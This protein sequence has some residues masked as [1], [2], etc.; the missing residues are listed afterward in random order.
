[1]ERL[2]DYLSFKN[3]TLFSILLILTGCG[4][5]VEINSPN[6]NAVHSP[7]STIEFDVSFVDI[8]ANDAEVMVNYREKGTSTYELLTELAANARVNVGVGVSGRKIRIDMDDDPTASVQSVESTDAALQI[9]E[10][11]IQKMLD[12]AVAVVFPGVGD[13]IEEIELPS[14]EGYSLQVLQIER[15]RKL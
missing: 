9:D 6:Q 1:V 7:V 14:I 15:G 5:K 11:I 4:G 13:L 12:Y 10:E 3:I 8:D 2:K